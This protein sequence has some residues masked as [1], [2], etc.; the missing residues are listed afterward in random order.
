[1]IEVR[2]PAELLTPCRMPV[3][4]DVEMNGDLLDMLINQSE[5]LRICAGKVDAII[6][7]YG[8]NYGNSRND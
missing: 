6:K 5:L 7:F 1:M 8:G 3:P 2:P 4:E